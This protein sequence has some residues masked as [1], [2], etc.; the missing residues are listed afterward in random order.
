MKCILCYI[1][2]AILLISTNG[3]S[4]HK[5]QAGDKVK[6]KVHF[7]YKKV[8]SGRATVIG[9]DNEDILFIQSPAQDI[10]RGCPVTIRI[11][12]KDLSYEG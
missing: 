1:S 10:D 11:P 4:A 8:C 6:Y 12:A 2:A 3:F 7:F 5:F 9:A